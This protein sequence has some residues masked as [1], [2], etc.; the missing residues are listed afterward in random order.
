MNVL[1]ISPC[2]LPIPAVKGG[3][4]ATLIESLIK[5]N[6]LEQKMN[7]TVVSVYSKEAEK[8]ASKYLYTEFVWIKIPKCINR[9]DLLMD[10][11]G[12]FTKKTGKAK[13]YLRK[14]YVIKKVNEI[15]INNTFDRVV[16]Q[17][18]GYLLKAINNNSLLTKYSEKIYYHLHNDIPINADKNILRKA[19]FILIS[20]YLKNGVVKACGKIVEE[21]CY[22]VK[23]GIDIRKYAQ[24]L[25]ENEKNKILKR[26]NI[27]QEKKIII[28]VGR[29]KPEKGLNEV[30][31]ALEKLDDRYI[32]LIIGSTNFG[33]DDIS[34]YEKQIQ[35][36]CIELDK[37]IVFTGY[38]PNQ[39]I[40]KYYKIANVAVLPS[41]W[42][43]PAGLTMIEAAAAGVPV[44]TT[45]SG[46]IP[47]YLND[48][49]AVFVERDK[50]IVDNLVRY[51]NQIVFDNSDYK[52][53]ANKAS[54]YVERN[55]SENVFYNV[56]C[57]VL[58]ENKQ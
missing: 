44:I 37:K 40:W 18:S 17:N 29:I 8:M 45:N 25:D 42:E 13:E 22:V 15:L 51:I 14:L 11:I 16:F 58:N 43:E 12:G 54:K 38:I 55:F 1:I 4:V 20:N 32:L 33:R 36:K 2:D 6:E 21:R 9:V 49:I 10:K 47:E 19:R 26:Y 35:R 28:F 27:S 53:M 3:A 23:N 7:L 31:S 56:F 46:G 24:F 57:E 39:E 48:D 50:D 34:D 52:E 41:M 5:I 30:L